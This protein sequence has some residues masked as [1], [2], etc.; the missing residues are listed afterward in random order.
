MVSQ[1]NA[2]RVNAQLPEKLREQVELLARNDD[3]SVSAIVR[4]AL[5]RLVEKECGKK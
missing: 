2:A 4:R 5:R 1:V 3:V